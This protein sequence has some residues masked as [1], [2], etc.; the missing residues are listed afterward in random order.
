[1]TLLERLKQIA[2]ALDQLL[3][4]LLN[5]LGID[6]YAD[7]TLSSHAYRM[8]RSG[9]PTGFLRN[10]IDFLFFWQQEHCYQSYLSEKYRR[11]LPPEFRTA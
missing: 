6:S 10:V 4:A 3:N 11:Q 2:I 8:W 7:E 9:K 5:L 1:M